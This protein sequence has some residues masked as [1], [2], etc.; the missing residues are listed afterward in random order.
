MVHKGVSDSHQKCCAVHTKQDSFIRSVGNYL[1][2]FL[3]KAAE[4]ECVWPC[5]Q[6][7]EFSLAFVTA[8]RKNT[9]KS[10][11]SPSKETNEEKGS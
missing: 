5:V 9:E 1:G 6:E 2:Q 4:G 3:C 7:L 11:L 8:K 10:Y